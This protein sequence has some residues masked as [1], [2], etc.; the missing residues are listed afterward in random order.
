MFIEA[1]RT[2][3]LYIG[4]TTLRISQVIGFACFVAGIILLL[5]NRQIYKGKPYLS[6]GGGNPEYA[7]MLTDRREAYEKALSLAKEKRI[8]KKKKQDKNT[9]TQ[10]TENI[11]NKDTENTGSIE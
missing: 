4:D 6:E 9:D 2:D 11:E 8:R 7:Q 5:R 3:S 1:L 10:N